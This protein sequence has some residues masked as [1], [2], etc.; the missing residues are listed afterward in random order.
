MESEYIVHTVGIGDNIHLLGEI[1]GVDWTEIVSLNGLEYPYIDSDVDSLEYQYRDDVAKI[2][3]K[4]VIPSDEVSFSNKSNNSS[5]EIE[6]YALGCDLDIF[7]AELGDHFNVANLE[8]RGQLTDDGYGDIKL[9]EGVENLRQQL[10]IRLG[11]RKGALSLHPEFGSNLL[12]WIGSK[13]TMELLIKTQL[14][15]EECL[16]TDERV[17]DVNDIV[18]AYKDKSVHID[19]KIVP[20]APYPSFDLSH[21]YTE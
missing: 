16:T 20:V 15:V 8:I 1:Y 3:S 17:V 6:K 7:S 13:V 10:I 12:D 11:T 2:G 19:C 18:V 9:C 5:E 21:T 4:L 14:E